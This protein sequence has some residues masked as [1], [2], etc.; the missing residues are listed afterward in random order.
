MLFKG[1]GPALNSILGNHVQVTFGTW[2]AVSRLVTAGQLRALAVTSA[3]RSPIIPNLPTLAESGLD[4]YDVTAMF[5]V[6]APAKTPGA[7]VKQLNQLIV[8]ALRSP[9]IQKRLSI[10]GAE[11]IAGSPKEFKADMQRDRTA[12]GKLVRSR[13]IGDN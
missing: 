1:T 5:G 8:Q 12:V 3:K 10:A 13:G 9:D 7:I 6:F 11:V 4:G 2:G